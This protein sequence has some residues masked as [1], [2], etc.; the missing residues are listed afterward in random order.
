MSGNTAEKRF[1]DTIR[2]GTSEL[3]L[4]DLSLEKPFLE[5]FRELK[6]WSRGYNLTGLEDEADIALD[7][8]IDS[9][10]YLKVIPPP[11]G[12][13][14]KLLDIGSGAGFPGLVLKIARPD[15]E[16][17]LLEP[18][19]KKAAFLRQVASRLELRD[20]RVLEM[21]VEEFSRTGDIFDFITTKALFSGYDFIRK[22]IP[23]RQ[24]GT[25]LLMNK[26]PRYRE[27]LLLVRKNIGEEAGELLFEIKKTTLPVSGKERYL[28]SIT[29]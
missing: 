4:Q 10:L 13:A 19:R 15:L 20:V 14:R 27:E 29:L 3:S 12:S 2:R 5:Y 9:L 8:F 6:R 21:R 24:K 23:L 17:T 16:T 1:L 25:L 26:G 18:S 28:I 11:D 7:L 22:T